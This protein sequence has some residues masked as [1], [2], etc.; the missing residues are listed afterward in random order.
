[1]PPARRASCTGTSAPPRRPRAAS[2]RRTPAGGGRPQ[3][4]TT[5]PRPGPADFGSFDPASGVITIKL[6]DSKADGT[7]LGPGDDLAAVNVR[8]YRSEER[9]VGKECRS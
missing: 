2:P 9:R 5:P 3:T 1:M 4:A 6:A 8:T 7:T